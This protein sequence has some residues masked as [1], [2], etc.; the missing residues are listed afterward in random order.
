MRVRI[1]EWF[2]W[3][4]VPDPEAFSILVARGLSPPSELR[5][6]A[7]AIRDNDLPRWHRKAFEQFSLV[8]IFGSS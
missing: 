4:A 5:R 2:S 3:Q 1:P 7:F 8:S 6:E